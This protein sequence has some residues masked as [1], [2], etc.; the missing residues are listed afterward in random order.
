VRPVVPGPRG[1]APPTGD[2]EQV[3]VVGHAGR[4]SAPTLANCQ[5]V[6]ERG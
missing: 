4:V 1:G 6:I 2:V 3:Q 5:R